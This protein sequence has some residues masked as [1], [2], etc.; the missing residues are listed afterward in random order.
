MDLTTTA[1]VAALIGKDFTHDGK[2]EAQIARLVTL[3]S[4]SFKTYLN[5]ETLAAA[6]TE[7]FTVT[8]GRMFDL[9]AYPVT[10]VTSVYN[11]S[12]RVWDTGEIDST[13]YYLN[14]ETGVITF[15]GVGLVPGPG[16]LRVIYAGGMAAD[17]AA[18]IAAF[19]DIADA[20]DMQVIAHYQ[21]RSQLSAQGVS[22]GGGNVSYTS[23]IKLLPG[24]MAVLGKYRRMA[25]A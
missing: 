12:S 4:N 7:Y 23:A 25:I 5:R 11:D 16:V 22:V 13:A 2:A 15:D 21:R 18:F 14:T 19:P 17:A 1:R 6:Q 10:S 9:K 20:C 8:D 24:V 3:Y